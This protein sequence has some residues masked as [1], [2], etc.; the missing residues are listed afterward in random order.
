MKIITEILI[1]C[2]ECG[3]GLKKECIVTKNSYGLNLYSDGNYH[4]D[5][6]NKIIEITRFPF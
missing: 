1:E 6:L 4:G 5:H 3:K 2:P